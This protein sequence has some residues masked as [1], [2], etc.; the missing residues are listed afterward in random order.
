MPEQQEH[1]RDSGAEDQQQRLRE[2]LEEH[3]Q[4]HGNDDQQGKAVAHDA[5]GFRNIAPALLNGGAGSAAHAYQ[6]GKG[7]DHHDDRQ[8]HAH[9]REGQLAHSLHRLHVAD[10]HPV[11]Q[12]IEHVDDLGGN[13]GQ[14]QGE[15]Q[16]SHRAGAQVHIFTVH[17]PNSFPPGRPYFQTLFPTGAKTP[18]APGGSGPPTAAARKEPAG[19]GPPGPEA[20][21][22]P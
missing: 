17:D 7:G 13:S 5:L 12:V 3:R 10:V 15:Q 21:L 22:D 20:H 18:A 8:A 16:L 9:T 4:H 2:E 14:S 19:A 11:H 6:R 1:P